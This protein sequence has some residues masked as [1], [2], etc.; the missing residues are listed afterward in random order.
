M[1]DATGTPP[2]GLR[3]RTV[4]WIQDHAL[5][6]GALALAA[7]IVAAA[8]AI[9]LATEASNDGEPPPSTGDNG[10]A[11]PAAGDLSSA[12]EASVSYAPTELVAVK[13]D[14]APGARP[15]I[16]LDRAR[17][18]I[19]APVEGGMTRFLAFFELGDTL[20]GPVRSVRHVDVDLVGLLSKTLVSTGGRPFVVGELEGNG[21]TMIGIDPENSP[22][23]QVERPAPHNLVVSLSGIVPN[24]PVTSGLPWG[25]LPEGVS[26]GAVPGPGGVSWR[27]EGGAYIRSEEGDPVQVLPGWDEA[28]VPLTVETV[29]VMTVNERSAGY[30]DV[31]GLEVPTFDV[32]GS[33]GLVVHHGGRSVEGSWSRASLI[34]PYVF[35]TADGMPFGLPP[36]RTFIHLVPH[37]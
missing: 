35:R 13:V 26:V 36:A 21:V 2:G 16:G 23:Q 28:P 5:A 14:N 1:P 30:Q 10:A 6:V 31:N 32:I 27:Y 19:E 7:V 8:L 33:G 18:V 34:A 9:A 3:Q 25:E 11:P 29:L 17:V 37:D 22:L 12:V 20:V 15:Q 4:T 24:S